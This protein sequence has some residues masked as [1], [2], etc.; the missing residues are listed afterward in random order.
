MTNFPCNSCGACCRNVHLAEETQ[1]LNR[2][3]GRC[4]YYNDDSKQCNIYVDRPSIC[5]VDEQYVI[6]YHPFMT[7]EAFIE[8]NMQACNKLNCL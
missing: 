6:N 3:D 5:R 7:W 2:G 8:L 1:Y 4:Q